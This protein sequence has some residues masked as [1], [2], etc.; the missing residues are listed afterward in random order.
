MSELTHVFSPFTIGRI[1]LKNRIVMAPIGGVYPSFEGFRCMEHRDFILARARGGVGTILLSGAGAGFTNLDVEVSPGELDTLVQAARELVKNVHD[2]GVCIGV[3]LHHS[4][5]Q[6][7]VPLP[8]AEVAGPSAVPWSPRAPVP[9]ELTPEEIKRLIQ[10]YVT[11]AKQVMEAGFDFVEVKACHGYLLGSFLSPR[12]NR[13]CD[14]YGGNLL[15]RARMITEIIQQVRAESDSDFLICCR[16][17]GSDNVDG[18][19]GLEES[20]TL[21]RILVNAGVDFLNVSAGV[22]GSYPVVIPP[23]DTPTGCYL[24]LSEAIKKRVQVPVMAVGRIND[25]RFADEILKSGKADLIAMGRALIA[26]PDLLLKAKEGRF[27]D[28]RKCIACNQG[29]F[30]RKSVVEATCLVNPAAMRENAMQVRPARV[31]KKVL[32]I[33]GGPAGMEAARV[34]AMRGHAVHLYEKESDLGGQWNLAAKAPGK[35]GFID[36]KTYLVTQVKKLG[37]QIHLGTE[38]T[39]RVLASESWDIAV[40]AAGATPL[41]PDFA[42]DVAKTVTAADVLAGKVVVGESVLIVGGNAVGLETAVFLAIRGKQVEIAEMA[43]R[44]GKDLG[45]TVSSH[46]RHRLNDLKI[47]ISYG[48]EVKSFDSGRVVLADE[49]NRKSFRDVDTVVIAIGARS[50]DDLIVS[51]KKRGLPCYIIGDALKPRNALFAMREGAEVG[52]K[53]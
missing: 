44:V 19:M 46:M 11:A 12:S 25:P 18:G 48:S 52:L 16:F 1:K 3:Q 30:D 45:A 37:V 8:G 14:D 13:R 7:D 49:D 23:Y 32:V 17:N 38:V 36:L 5:R 53:I 27:E 31:P 43:N 50:K 41:I 26:D 51:L 21:S 42:V 39:D 34:A 40:L 35:E 20:Q 10:R 24:H 9:R 33:G 15:N 28:I 29:C 47:K 2:E 6:P 4:G 22:Y